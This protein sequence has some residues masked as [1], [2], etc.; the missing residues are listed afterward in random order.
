[1]VLF[2]AI[3]VRE[4]WVYYSMQSNLLNQLVK[5]SESDMYPF[6]MP[7]HKRQSMHELSVT[8]YDITE[9][10]GFD[11]LY[12]PEGLLQQCMERAATVYG[13]RKAL[14]GVNGSTGNLL[15]AISAAFHPGDVVL[16][17]RN[18]HK[19]VYH[20]LELRQLKPKFIYPETEDALCV[21][22]GLT[23]R[24]VQ[25]WLSAYE[26]TEEGREHP[27]AGMI[28]TSPTYEG[29][30]S[31]INEIAA[32]LHERNAV[33]IVDEAHGAHFGFHEAFPVSAVKEG[34]DLV[35]QSLHKTLPAMTQTSL[36][37][38]A[39]NRVC[40]S[41][42]EKYFSMYQTSSPS[43]ILMSSMELCIAVLE[44]EAKEVFSCYARLL[45]DFYHKMRKLSV[46]K[47]LPGE[48][49]DPGK[50]VISVPKGDSAHCLYKLLREKYHL[51][52]EMCGL[53]HVLMMTSVFDTQ[54]GFERLKSALL[55]IDEEWKNAALGQRK[56]LCP[57]GKDK[58]NGNQAEE[59]DGFDRIRN[60][61]TVQCMMPAKTEGEET[62]FVCFAASAGRIST[63]YLYLYPPGIPYVIPGEEVPEELPPILMILQEKG[64]RLLGNQQKEGLFVLKKG[65]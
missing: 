16:V 65:K 59:P 30:V 27:V 63:E 22:K 34:A 53:R 4:H 14:L 23:G 37:H 7:G 18:C 31:Q 60:I 47:V 24:E 54:E 58:T 52:P 5:L 20:A 12:A 61:R 29:F 9:I 17:A 36:L 8:K 62:E 28:L 15:A 48:G 55:E 26:A 51:Q 3:A 10:D 32:L 35:I 45:E 2:Q 49:R 6:H 25:T 57:E 39:T 19:A 64:Y 13:S 56:K 21:C 11:N 40:A 46:L 38:I 50:I 44:H 42:V 41:R 1:M 33:L 43:Y